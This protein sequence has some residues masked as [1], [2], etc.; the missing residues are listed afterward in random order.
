MLFALQLLL[1]QQ[2][3]TSCVYVTVALACLGNTFDLNICS[4]IKR[5]AAKPSK[6]LV[7]ATK[8]MPS[9]GAAT[10]IWRVP[11]QV[12]S[13]GVGFSAVPATQV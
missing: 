9:A 8:L 13:A 10:G 1:S 7:D 2:S 4:G 6:G 11:S 5:T 3:G 12:S